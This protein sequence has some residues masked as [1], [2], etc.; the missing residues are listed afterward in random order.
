MNM[1]TLFVCINVGLSILALPGTPFYVN[2]TDNC[3]FPST[4]APPVDPTI[5]VNSTLLAGNNATIGTVQD[6]FITPTNSTLTAPGWITTNP[7]NSFLDTV[8]QAAKSMEVMKNVIGGG[9]I[10]GVIDHFSISCGYDENGTLID[11]GTSP[12]WTTF[13]EGISVV[14]IMLTIFTLFYWITG[15]GHILTS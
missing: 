12:V 14:I 4:G 9:Y 11:F 3:Y 6:E 13:K 15:R 8:D 2:G 10:F 5:H 1:L 7:L